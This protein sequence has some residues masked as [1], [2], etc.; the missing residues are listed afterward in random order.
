MFA[1]L[2]ISLRLVKP[3]IES[4][5]PGLETES[6]LLIAAV[7]N[8]NFEYLGTLEIVEDFIDIINNV[9]EVKKKIMVL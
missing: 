5:G 8:N 2:L 4:S 3:I 9:E 1:T 7:R 6:K